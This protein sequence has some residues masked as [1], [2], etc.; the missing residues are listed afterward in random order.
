MKG[1]MVTA[2]VLLLSLREG[3]SGADQRIIGGYQT[4]IE[5]FPYQAWLIVVSEKSYYRECG[6]SVLNEKYVLTSAV[7]GQGYLWGDS[8]YARCGFTNGAE[9]TENSPYIKGQLKTHPKFNPNT[10]DYDC[11][12][13]ELE[14]NLKLNGKTIAPVTLAKVGTELK[15]GTKLVVAG[16]GYTNNKGDYSQNLQA[17]KV[18]VQRYGICIRYAKDLTMRMGC[19]EGQ[20]ENPCTGDFGGA[21][22]MEDTKE[23]VG[24]ASFASIKGRCDKYPVV[25]TNTT[26]GEIRDW[27]KKVSGV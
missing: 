27:I 24:I 14:E 4:T 1:L 26:N 18:V 23:Q 17:A 9:S 3:A 19:V 22:V 11:G 16:W 21:L 12:V 7:C 20:G 6:G 8:V 2:T 5:K 15:A 10:M 25:F 13:V